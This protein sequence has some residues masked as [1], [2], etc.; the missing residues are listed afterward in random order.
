M[1]IIGLQVIGSIEVNKEVEMAKIGA[2]GLI[3]TS[4]NESYIFKF[5]KV[6]G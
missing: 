1:L 2:R 4:N 6:E 3:L 5:P